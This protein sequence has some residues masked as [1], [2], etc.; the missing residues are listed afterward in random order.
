[1]TMMLGFSAPCT[2][3]RLSTIKSN[4]TV[5]HCK[6]HSDLRG[7]RVQDAMAGSRNIQGT[8]RFAKIPY[9]QHVGIGIDGLLYDFQ[10]RLRS[11]V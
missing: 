6:A 7:N 8:N 2:V 10:C 5:A 3:R 11:I 1:M 9:L 4:P